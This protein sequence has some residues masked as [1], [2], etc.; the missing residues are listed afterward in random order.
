MGNQSGIQ[1]DVSLAG[2]LGV[3]DSQRVPQKALQIIN[4]KRAR[5]NTLY[6]ELN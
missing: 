6:N 3:G 2:T 4:V 1:L 5:E